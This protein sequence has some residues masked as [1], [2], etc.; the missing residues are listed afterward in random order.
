MKLA[1]RQ[2]WLGVF[3]SGEKRRVS[4]VFRLLS[5]HP[6][7]QPSPPLSQSPSSYLDL[8]GTVEAKQNSFHLT[9]TQLCLE[10]KPLG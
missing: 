6:A 2:G 1:L 10:S 4:W 5:Y 8:S 7:G 9:F 3:G